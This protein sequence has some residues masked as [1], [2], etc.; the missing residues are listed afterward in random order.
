VVW[1]F[2]LVSGQVHIQNLYGLHLIL[3]FKLSSRQMTMHL[4]SNCYQR[5]CTFNIK[6]QCWSSP[7]EFWHQDF[8]KSISARILGHH[9]YN[10]ES[11]RKG[12]RWGDPLCLAVYAH[13]QHQQEQAWFSPGHGW[14]TFLWFC[15]SIEFW[16][17]LLPVYRT[18]TRALRD[19][20]GELTSFVST[21]QDKR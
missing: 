5:R 11:K 13:G 4:M 14:L 7:C 10:V 2:S 15:P 20:P 18:F 12:R 16:H 19:V 8:P 9:R 3:P 21:R 6:P 17:T 1:W